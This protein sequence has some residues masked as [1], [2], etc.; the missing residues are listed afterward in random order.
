MLSHLAVGDGSI[1]GHVGFEQCLVC[2]DDGFGKDAFAGTFTQFSQF[3]LKGHGKVL[4]RYQFISERPLGAPA[5]AADSHGP[6]GNVLDT[7]I[8]ADMPD[9]ACGCSRADMPDTAAAYS[10]GSP[11]EGHT[12]T[13]GERRHRRWPVPVAAVPAG[14]CAG[15][16]RA[17]RCR[18]VPGQSAGC[19]P[20]RP[21]CACRRFPR[22]GRIPS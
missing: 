8:V 18:A 19:G 2:R 16:R 13:A 14:A 11:A 3:F 9:A 22:Q 21:R 1:D 4:L 17:P 15:C 10:A 12:S 6:A 7:G 20:A 5:L